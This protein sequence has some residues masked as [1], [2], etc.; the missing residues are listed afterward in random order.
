MTHLDEVFGVVAGRLTQFRELS[1]DL[2]T[3]ELSLVWYF[4][5]LK[6]NAAG[7]LDRVGQI[8]YWRRFGNRLGYLLLLAGALRRLRG[9]S[10]H[11]APTSLTS[12]A[13]LHV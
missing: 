4:I 8:R 13:V 11:L 5:A 1:P 12:S 7:V 10:R 2:Q 3:L 6:G 9:L